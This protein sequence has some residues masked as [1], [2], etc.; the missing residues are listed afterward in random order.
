[1]SKYKNC[2]N[3]CQSALGEPRRECAW[4]CTYA[5]DVSRPQQTPRCTGCHC[6][7]GVVVVP[8]HDAYV[9]LIVLK[10]E[11]ERKKS[12]PVP[13]VFLYLSRPFPYLRKYTKM[14]REVGRGVSC[15]YL[16]DLVFSRNNPVF[17]KS[18]KKIIGTS[19]I[20]SY[21]STSIH[22]LH[23]LIVENKKH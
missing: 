20:L 10:D 4:T 14:V 3:K 11:N 22:V 2:K 15:Q 8:H 7:R 13:P 17:K 18:G 23:D 16:H 19:Y 6:S 5:S 9:S 12:H 1:M 21:S